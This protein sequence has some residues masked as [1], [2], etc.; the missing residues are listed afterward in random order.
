MRL[1]VM[2]GAMN[3]VR[4]MKLLEELA[5]RDEVL[6][7]LGEEG[8]DMTFTHY[9]RSIRYMTEVRQRVNEKIKERV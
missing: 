3:D 7:C 2:D 8:K 6:K 4:A 5:G 1:I 9:P